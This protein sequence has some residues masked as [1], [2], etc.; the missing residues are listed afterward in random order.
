[1]TENQKSKVESPIMPLEHK[2]HTV[3]AEEAG[4]V[5]LIV[6]AITGRSRSQLRG[7]CMNGCLSINGQPITEP[8]TAVKEGDT[9]DVKY[10]PQRKYRE[11]WLGKF[12][13]KSPRGLF[14]CKSFSV[15]FEDDYLIVVEKQAGILTVPTERQEPRTL[16]DEVS[17]YLGGRNRALVVHRLD[18]ETS[19][20]MVF[21]KRSEIAGALQDQLRLR[22]PDRVYLALVAGVM[23]EDAGQFESYLATSKRLSRY[24]VENP[25]G[26]EHAI[27]HFEIAERLFDTTL[28]RVKLDTGRRNQ[29]RVH[30]SEAGHPIIGDRRYQPDR[31]R[32]PDWPH[33][34]LAL[35][36][37]VLGFQ[38]PV[39]GEDLRFVSEI[40]RTF[41]TF[42]KLQR[43]AL[44]QP[45]ES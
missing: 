45:Q 29:I 40:P 3:T 35:H 36:A 1:V 5:D 37:H 34:R 7:M 24:S 20:V 11:T 27:T 9:I 25:D 2:T 41:Q 30:L 10:D 31:A 28:V 15:M 32:H 17:R 44:Q 39:T 21:A 19:G 42:M 33:T 12:Q 6:K 16:V 14:E 38:H 22:A 26:G 4:R 18:R 8:S 13:S 43:R 23:E